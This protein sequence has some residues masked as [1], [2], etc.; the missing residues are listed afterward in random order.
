[1][2]THNL[3]DDA[4]DPILNFLRNANLLNHESDKVK[5]VY[6]PDF[7][8][9]TN[10][11]FGM[12][13]G[14]FVRGCHL[15]VFPSYYEPWGYTPVECLARGVSAITSDLSGFGNYIKQLPKGDENHGMY[16]I[17]RED[18]DFDSVAEQLCEKLLK[19]VK[20]TSKKR[21]QT[22]NKAEDLSEEFDWKNLID[23]YE[24]AYGLACKQFSF[25]D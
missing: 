1:M 21:I 15:G 20:G 18:K 16:L 11:L 23:H 14:Q 13:Y 10:P 9:S 22:R 4:G 17:E 3:N 5:I 2:V 12:E 8:S 7:I 19:F 25:D 6:H 24:H